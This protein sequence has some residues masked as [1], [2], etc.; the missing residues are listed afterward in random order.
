MLR[1][2]A[3]AAWR[4]ASASARAREPARQH[5]IRFFPNPVHLFGQPLL[6]LEPDAIALR[7][8]RLA[9]HRLG[10]HARFGDRG[11]ALGGRLAFDALDLAG[12]P[13][14]GLGLHAGDLA[15][16]RGLHLGGVDLRRQH[17]VRF[18]ADP[19]DLFGQLPL[20]LAPDPFEL[21]RQAFARRGFG[22]RARFGHRGFAL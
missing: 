2:S 10:C 20:R 22:G 19:A 13:A 21:R 8:Q 11:F 5:P 6:R 12:A 4:P 1:A 9:R 3:M 15:V 16:A 18:L 7:R 14:R 17:P